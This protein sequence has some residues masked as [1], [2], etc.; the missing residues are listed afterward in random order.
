VVCR[1]YNKYEQEEVSCDTSFLILGE[2]YHGRI[3]EKFG[4]TIRGRVIA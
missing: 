4:E 3:A 2:K 1:R